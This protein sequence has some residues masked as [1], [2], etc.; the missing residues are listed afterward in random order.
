[1]TFQSQEKLRAQ[2]GNA[3]I[4]I[5]IAVALFAALSFMLGRQ[6]DTSEVAAL[7]REKAR[8]VANQIVSYAAQ[9]K[10][11][12]DNMLFAN[13]R[14]EDLDFTTPDDRDFNDKPTIR[15]IFHPDGGGLNRGRIPKEAQGIN[16]SDPPAGWYMGRFNNVDWTPSDRED[17]I[18]TAHNIRQGVCEQLNRIIT[19]STDIP[20]LKTT[21]KA[22]LIDSETEGYGNGLNVDFDTQGANPSCEACEKLVSLCVRSGGAAE[23]SFY[24]VLIDR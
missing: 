5:L 1:M 8:I 20:A 3:L 15:K 6:T 10:Q 9:A 12:V 23:F 13:T 18:L 2:R 22:V 16:K 17:V 19:G 24:S 4:Y 14:Y 11:S 7:D 21:T